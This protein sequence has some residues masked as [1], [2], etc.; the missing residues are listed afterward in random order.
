MSSAPYPVTIQQNL[1]YG[2]ITTQ[3]TGSN[4][5]LDLY[6]PVGASGARPCVVCFHGGSWESGIKDAYFVGHVSYVQLCTQLA[7][8]GYAAAS[9]NYR[10]S[11]GAS[12]AAV[13]PAQINDAQLA[14]R[15]LRS[16][17]ASNNIDP[18][19][20][21]AWGDS[22]GS[23]LALYL[24]V[25]STIHAGDQSGN[26][27]G[28]SP[29]VQACVDQFGP[30]DLTRLYNESVPGQ[31]ALLNLMNGA[32]PTSNPSLYADGSPL[33]QLA[34]RVGP[35]YIIQGTTDTTV[36][37][38]QSMEL[39]AALQ[40]YGSNV[41]FISYIGE[42]EYGGLSLAPIDTLRQGAL[43]FIKRQFPVT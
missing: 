31:A 1:A 37:E 35:V 7:A 16:I 29:Q 9:C 36:I 38:D 18:A 41:T 24:L 22:A 5:L 28:Y 6:T 34:G 25:A 13:W 39:Y 26:L 8:L 3:A 42:H 2:S 30:T 4:Q 14:I 40:S 20:F 12:T 10:Y 23:H 11:N 33:S 15:Y 19:R 17:A 21:V 32:T 43:N 27:T